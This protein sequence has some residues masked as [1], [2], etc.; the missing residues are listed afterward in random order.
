VTGYDEVKCKPPKGLS[1]VSS[2]RITFTMEA[3]IHSK[4]IPPGY[5]AIPIVSL[6]FKIEYF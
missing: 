6:H 4:E 3:E 1:K 2:E 5:E